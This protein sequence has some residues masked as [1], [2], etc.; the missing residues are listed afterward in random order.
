MKNSKMKLAIRF[1]SLMLVLVMVFASAVPMTVSA[2]S[3]TAETSQTV[4]IKVGETK[5]LRV[6]ALSVKWES[7]DEAVV[8]VSERGVIKGVSVGTATVTASYKSFWGIFTGKTSEK[9]FQVTVKEGTEVP[10]APTGGNQVK[11]GETLKLTV[12]KSGTT[13]WKSSDEAVATVSGDGVVTGVS[14]GTVTITATTKSGGYK[15]WFFTW[16]GTTTTT[17]FEVEVVA[18]DGPVEPDN[19]VNPDD[20]T[21]DP[22]DPT[23]EPDNPDDPTVDPENPDASTEDTITEEDMQVDN[24]DDGLSDGIEEFLGTDKTKDDTDEDGLS[25]ELEVAIGT[26]PAMEDSD[27]DGILDGEEDQDGDGLTNLNELDLGT[28]P[29]EDD[30]D[31]DGL[32]DYDEIYTYKT[33]PLN[34]DTD[35]D[36]AYDGWETAHGYDPLSFNDSFDVENSTSTDEVT[37]GVSLKA[38]GDQVA[39]LAVEEVED[40]PLLDTS[41]PG[42][43][44]AAFDFSIDGAFEEAVISFTFDESYLSDSTFDPVIYYFNEETQCLEELDTTVEGN[45]ASATVTHFSTYILL[46]RRDFDLVWSTEIKP[47]I[48]D[49]EGKAASIDVAFVIDC[50]GSMSSYSRM[51]TAKEA[52]ETFLNA[53]GE[54]DRAAL[55]KF[56]SS[57]T[58]LSDL[59]TDKSSVKTLVNSLSASGQTAMYTGLD[60]AIDMLS[61]K[62]Q[63]YGYKMIIA[64]SDGKDEPST[65]YDGHYASLVEQAKANNIVVYT[66]G[67]GTSVETSILTQVAANTGG[68]Y[69]AAAVTS[70]ITDA[71]TEIKGDTVDL[72]TDS[73]ND[74]IS[75][76]FTE[77]LCDGSLKL[78]TGMNNPFYEYGAEYDDIQM[79][80]DGDY[81]NDGLLNGQ[82]LVVKYVESL[83]R[84]YVWLMSDPTSADTDYDGI[85]DNEESEKNTNNNKF[86]ADVSYMTS[87][88]E[89]SF[90]AEFNVDYR[91]FFKDN[92]KFQKKLAVLASLY[93]LDMY[94][95]K[96]IGGKQGYGYITLTSGANGT[97]KGNNGVAFGELF[98]LNDCVNINET[99]FVSPYGRVDSKGNHVDYDDIAEAFIG[100]RLVSYK[101]E[102]RE[103]IFLAVR[104]TNG[105]QAEWAS[106]FDIGSDTQAYYDKTGEHPDW[107]N[108]KNHKGFDVT[109]NRIITAFNQYVADLEAKGKMDPSIPRSIFIT[110]HSRG[111]GIANLLGAHFEKEAN[112]KSYTYT[113]ASPYTT[114]DTNAESYNTIFNIRNKDDLVTYLPLYDWG[115]R[116]Y[117]ETLTISIEDKYE[118]TDPI[119]NAKGTFE[120]LFGKDYN[121]NGYVDDAEDAF[122]EMTSGRDSYYVLDTKSGD[123]VVMDG[124]VRYGDSDVEFKAMLDAG[125]LINTPHDYSDVKKNQLVVGYTLEVT[126]CPA[127]AAQLVSNLASADE[128]NE[129]YPDYGLFTWLGVDLKGVYS[130]ARKQFAIASGKVSVAGVGPGG[131]ECPHIPGSYYLISTNTAYDNYAK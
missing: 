54:K 87:D 3:T 76:Y 121:S 74:G 118:D 31:H 23:V 130:N 88:T 72:T 98:G 5:T 83:N 42:Y 56:T 129:R 96:S 36:G 65:T 113:M 2:A 131:M 48:T 8:T 78:G 91:L 59:T 64:L 105:T 81:D 70:G 101:G 7:S 128:I 117:G 124:F 75:D 116:K 46:N 90:D 127:Y 108:K 60:M 115:F 43:I 49:E 30:T 21:V 109:A 61:D 39:T 107:L 20:P 6:S 97:T 77:K 68:A 63:T 106:N 37:A 110:G 58:K 13:T 11:V 26:D 18:G 100:H 55:V 80:L 93:S 4:E 119:G 35:N 32:N 71:F 67:A 19:P 122:K 99:E 50:S 51:K 82:E 112:Y 66:I 17:K 45:V 41:L 114:T 27:N 29:V 24:D 10:D 111:A 104:G 57:A 12:S 9:Q 16:G 86:K 95:E 85:D 126:Y 123:G 40:N 38:T 33:Q 34:K 103:I 52:L 14:E 102:Q 73:N 79:D 92:T 69:Y 62:T 84:V 94:E 53:L 44:G 89:Y 120:Y 22:D 15:F 125:K 1:F 47:P 28:D 25:D